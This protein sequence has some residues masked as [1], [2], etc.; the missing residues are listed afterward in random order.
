MSNAWETLV[1]VGLAQL[2][3]S[4]LERIG[5][6]RKGLITPPPYALDDLHWE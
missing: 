2:N 1:A 4:T 3:F 6:F 5:F